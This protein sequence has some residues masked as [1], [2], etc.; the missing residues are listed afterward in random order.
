VSETTGCL[1]IIEA[2]FAILVLLVYLSGTLLC[3]IQRLS[4]S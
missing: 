3:H 4:G 2:I 1:L